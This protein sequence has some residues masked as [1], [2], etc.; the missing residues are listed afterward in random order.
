MC[1][2]CCNCSNYP[3]VWCQRSAACRGVCREAGPDEWRRLVA[4][5]RECLQVCRKVAR[6]LCRLICQC[7]CC[8][9][10]YNRKCN[11]KCFKKL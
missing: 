4:V 8:F 9:G 7:L 1:R 3:F 11:K 10:K 2:R 5:C 6:C